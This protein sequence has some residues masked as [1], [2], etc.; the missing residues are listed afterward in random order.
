M[1][2]FGAP[3]LGFARNRNPRRQSV[4]T[5]YGF[6]RHGHCIYNLVL[7]MMVA[8]NKR[9]LRGRGLIGTSSRRPFLPRVL[10]P[11]NCHQIWIIFEIFFILSCYGLPRDGQTCSFAYEGRFHFGSQPRRLWLAL[12]SSMQLDK[13][14]YWVLHSYCDIIFNSDNRGCILWAIWQVPW[15]SQFLAGA[16]CPS[17]ASPPQLSSAFWKSL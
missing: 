7:T 2:L 11:Q 13:S 12:S 4:L 10:F 9:E 15:Q 17:T 14:K 1:C 3:H 8:H 6:W 16:R 5:G